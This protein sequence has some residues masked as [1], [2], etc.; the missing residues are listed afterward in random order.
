[1]VTSMRIWIRFLVGSIIGVAL[2]LWLPESGGDT[3]ALFFGLSALV[4]NVGRYL[5][6]PLV[7]FGLA[8]GTYELMQ[9]RV[10]LRVYAKTAVL[11]LASSAGMI[12]LGTLAVLFLA[13]ARVPP[14]FQETPILALPTLSQLLFRVFPR[15]LF[16]A[17]ADDG[18]FLLPVAVVGLLLGVVAGRSQRTSE[19]LIQLFDSAARAFYTLVSWLMEILGIGMIAVSAAFVFEL[20]AI[21]DFDIFSQLVLVLVFT[22]GLIIFVIFPLILYFVT[23]RENPFIWLFALIVPVL[24]AVF[25]RDAFF[26]VPPLLRVGKENLGIPRSVGSAVF[27]FAAVFAKGGTALVTAATFILILRSFTALGITFGQVLWVMT[28][29]FGLSF[30]LGSAPGSGVLIALSLLSGFY[31]RGMEEVFLIVLP[32]IPIL[33]SIGVVLDVITTA[34][35]ASLVA[36]SERMRKRVDHLDFI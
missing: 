34:F 20:R 33:V 35:V 21:I 23:D 2:G 10:A 22:V 16:G 13:P 6:F 25:S 1:M 32:I 3:A 29:T 7:F 18:N 27:S 8:I 11:V 31:G 12:V 4:V 28:A 15:N 9:E 24:S 5:L 14:I 17:F 30:L 26:A 19:P 36:Y